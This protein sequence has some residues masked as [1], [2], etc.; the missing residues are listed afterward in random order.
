MLPETVSQVY[1]LIYRSIM[2][3]HIR[4]G[5]LALLSSAQIF[6]PSLYE[7]EKKESLSLS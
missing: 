5:T 6:S 3:V 2:T 4:Y 7:S 1:L